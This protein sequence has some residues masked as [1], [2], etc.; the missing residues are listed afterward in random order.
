[1]WTSPGTHD[2]R[3]VRAT[4]KQVSNRLQIG[5]CAQCRT[6]DGAIEPSTLSEGSNQPGTCQVVS[7][8]GGTCVEETHY[9]IS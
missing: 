5:D 2:N 1:M 3:N 6:E 8:I 7:D 9:K 4:I